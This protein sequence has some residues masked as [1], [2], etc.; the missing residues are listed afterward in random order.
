VF[1]FSLISFFYRHFNPSLHCPSL[2]QPHYAHAIA[3][4]ILRTRAA[5]GHAPDAPLEIIEFGGGAGTCALDILDHLQW[6][7]GALYARTSYT[8]VELSARLAAEQRRRV[9][10]RHAPERYRTVEASAVDALRHRPR[11]AAPAFVI[12]LEV[13]DNMPHDKVVVHPETGQV[14]ETWV[15][16]VQQQPQ[17]QAPRAPADAARKSAAQQTHTVPGYE[18]SSGAGFI[19]QLRPMQDPLVQRAWAHYQAIESAR[20]PP[21]GIPRMLQQVRAFFNSSSSS[22]SS[23]PARATARSGPIYLPTVCLQMLD[24]LRASL[25]D[26]HALL[27][28]FNSLPSTDTIEGHLAPIVASKSGAANTDHPT[29]LVPLGA[30]DVFFPTDFD[31]LARAYAVDAIGVPQ[32]SL[33]AALAPTS[34]PASASAATAAHGG[35]V[36]PVPGGKPAPARVCSETLSQRDFLL[37]Y[38]R[39]PKQ[40]ETRNGDNPML[41][42]YSNMSVLITTPRRGLPSAAAAAAAAAASSSFTAPAPQ[43]P[44]AAGGDARNSSQ[45]R[46]ALRTDVPRPKQ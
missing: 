28:D 45:R 13:L 24:R 27:A 11:A 41:D 8:I 20:P 33:P 1:S 32:S 38:A 7:H 30:A 21:K 34:A 22:S 43:S 25:P 46:P 42:D 14:Y 37:R 6:S 3:Q 12:A 18:P 23:S 2:S 19:E 31:L 39:D 26:H 10:A 36:G 16:P 17:Q 9:G 4:W 35:E 15:V 44:Q 29:Y 40:T 5:A